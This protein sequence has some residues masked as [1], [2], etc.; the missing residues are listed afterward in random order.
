MPTNKNALVRYKILD[1]CFRNTGRKYNIDNL[2]EEC[3]KTLAE[4]DP[5]SNGISRRQIY[6]DITF[7]E[8]LEGWEIELE[9]TKESRKTYYRYQDPSFSINN[10]P[11]NDLEINQLKSAMEI[12]AQFKGMPQF[13]WVHELEPK[14]KIGRAHV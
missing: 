2:M 9:K 5:K 4:I 12:L 14:L 11:L 7:M 1:R 13:E 3:N 8:S 10:M 6:A